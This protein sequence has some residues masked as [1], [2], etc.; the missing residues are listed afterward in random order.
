MILNIHGYKGNSEN[1]MYII[2]KELFPTR[3]I[4]SPQLDYD[5]YSP[6]EIRDKLNN[7]ADKE[8]D[9]IVGTSLGGFFCLDLWAKWKNIPAIIF[10]P[11]LTPWSLLPKLGYG[12]SAPNIDEFKSVYT[13]FIS[14]VGDKDKLYAIYGKQDEVLSVKRTNGATEA[15]G[16]SAFILTKELT[17]T[18]DKVIIDGMKLDGLRGCL[19]ACEINCG[20]SAAGNPGALAVIKEIILT[21]HH[22]NYSVT[23]ARQDENAYYI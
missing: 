2:L 3:G 21:L 19:N 10:N 4:L 1:T 13:H 12:Y 22:N 14:N 8:I 17:L 23:L 7:V 11:V 5:S 16:H 18:S 9:L 15:F 6:F 20:H